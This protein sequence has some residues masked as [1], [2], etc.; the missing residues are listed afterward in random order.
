MKH[1]FMERIEELAETLNDE[2]HKHQQDL[3]ATIFLHEKKTIDDLEALAKSYSDDLRLGLTAED[4]SELVNE[5]IEQE[6]GARNKLA[7]GF[8]ATV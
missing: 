5:A 1:I 8:T 7:A 6:Y 4:L 3:L 2:A